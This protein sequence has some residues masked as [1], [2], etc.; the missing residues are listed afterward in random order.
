M[1]DAVAIE[2][3]AHEDAAS[4]VSSVACRLQGVWLSPPAHELLQDEYRNVCFEMA[5]RVT[6]SPPRRSSSAAPETQSP[7]SPGTGQ[8][9][10]PYTNCRPF[11]EGVTSD[12]YRCG[13]RALKVITIHR[14][15]EPHNPQREIRI[16][17]TLRPPC[18]PLLEEF[19]DQQ[20]RLVL[21]FPFM[22]CSLAG[23]LDDGM[24]PPAQLRSIFSDVLRGLADIHS[25]GIVHRDIKPSA[26][27]LPSPAG[28]A[29][30]SD[31]GTAWH[32]S[33]SSASEPADEKILD[34]GT[35]PYRAPEVLFGNRSYGAPVDMWAMGVMLSEA[36][37]SPPRP[38][39]ESRP[40]H[41]DGNQLG[42]ILSIFK[43]LG[44]PTPETWPEAKAF[45]VTPFDL[46][47]V[48]PQR[49]W[50]DILPDLEESW[51]D[52]VAAL[53]RYGGNRITA[54]QVRAFPWFEFPSV[55]DILIIPCCRLWR[56]SVSRTSRLPRV[57]LALLQDH[58]HASYY[59]CLLFAVSAP[60]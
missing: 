9:I 26:V 20:Q 42:L 8:R 49:P 51:R 18:I 13:S 32:P 52:L 36:L 45:K 27:L 30:I 43:T 25:R 46:W 38:I 53:V 50:T 54:E 19:R 31:F 60:R 5:S 17:R 7:P 12:V 6:Q 33:F 21:V 28:P 34:I 41:E 59:V 55:P 40:V 56:L 44:T 3:A 57:C 37:R 16:L 15:V 23:L 10:G 2:Q 1:L 58:L 47:T 22:A 39:F 35:G 48:F 29:C 14:P 4:L 24:L 11:A